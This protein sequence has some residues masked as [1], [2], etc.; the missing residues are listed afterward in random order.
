MEDPDPNR[1]TGN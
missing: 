1:Y